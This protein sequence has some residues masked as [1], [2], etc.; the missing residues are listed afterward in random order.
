MKELSGAAMSSLRGERVAVLGDVDRQRIDELDR[1][2][3]SAPL[4]SGVDGQRVVTLAERPR[5]NAAP[6]GRHRTLTGSAGF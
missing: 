5:L 4:L 2:G 6:H 3:Q 1:L